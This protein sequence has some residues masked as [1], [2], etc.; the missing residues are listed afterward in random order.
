M[1]SNNDQNRHCTDSVPI[2][3]RFSNKKKKELANTDNPLK[4]VVKEKF[5]KNKN[6]MNTL[7]LENSEDLKHN[8]VPK[9]IAKELQQMR[10]AKG[11]SQ[12]ELANKL[13]IKP[14]E[15]Q[16]IEQGKA[17]YNK[18]MISKIKRKLSS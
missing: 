2:I 3:I 5:A 8:Y 14:Q 4:K 16:L 6:N 18:Q 11:W 15:I 9:K 13:R 10:S 12:K 17:I 7:K 1:L